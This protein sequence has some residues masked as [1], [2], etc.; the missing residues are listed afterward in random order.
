MY[1]E[2]KQLPEGWVIREDGTVR[3]GYSRWQRS[4]KWWGRFSSL[5]GIGEELGGYK[6]YGYATVVEILSAALQG[7]CILESTVW[8]G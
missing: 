4:G 2:G 1:E 6:G 8:Y 7:R 5:G 3:T